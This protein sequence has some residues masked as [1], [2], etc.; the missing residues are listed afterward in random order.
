LLASLHQALF[1]ISALRATVLDL[2]S[3]GLAEPVADRF[4]TRLDEA[5]ST[6]LVL[7]D[8]AE[9]IRGVAAH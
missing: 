3:D 4:L 8:R 9:S 6:A 1:R 7:I 5:E 2:N